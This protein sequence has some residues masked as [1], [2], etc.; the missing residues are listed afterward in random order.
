MAQS[1][2][3][4]VSPTERAALDGCVMTIYREWAIPMGGDDLTAY[5]NFFTRYVASSGAVGVTSTMTPAQQPG[6][7]AG[8]RRQRRSATAGQAPAA[9]QGGTPTDKR[10]PASS[11]DKLA[12]V[13]DKIVK[14]PATGITRET[15]AKALVPTY[16]EPNQ[17]G[18]ALYRL[19]Q[20]NYVTWVDPKNGPFI[21]TPAGIEA[22]R[23]LVTSIN[24][25]RR[26]RSRRAT[27]TDA[28]TQPG[29]QVAA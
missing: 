9:S 2:T 28:A 7:P 8:T 3:T 1:T 13:L 6:T 21:A 19:R 17:V 25:G 12:R 5:Q 29:E 11:G 20:R 22:N 14:G 15:I 18:T 24:A 26:S 23:E 4:P 10:E 16:M 27:Q